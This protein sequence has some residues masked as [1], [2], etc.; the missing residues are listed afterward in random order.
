MIQL[1]SCSDQLPRGSQP[2]APFPSSGRWAK[3]NPSAL[4]A[5]FHW[6]QCRQ[7]FY[8]MP[9]LYEPT[10]P[11]CQRGRLEKIGTWDLREPWWPLL[12]EVD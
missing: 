12:R 7:R 5:L 8:G 2:D 3:D 9:I 11:T 10:C 6:S 4:V 1:S